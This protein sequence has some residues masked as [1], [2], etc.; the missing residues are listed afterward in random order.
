M[1]ATILTSHGPS[2]PNVDYLYNL[3]ASMRELVPDEEDPHL[4]ELEAEVKRQQEA[5]TRAALQAD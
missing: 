1:A 3:A 2:G 4:E 5:A